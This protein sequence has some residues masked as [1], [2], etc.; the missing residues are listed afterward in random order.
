MAS[1]VAN[2]SAA[3]QLNDQWAIDILSKH[4]CI[5]RVPRKLRQT[6][7]A[8]YTPEVVPIGPFYSLR[9]GYKKMEKQKQKYLDQ[10]FC[11][12]TGKK[13]ED[14]TSSR[15]C[16]YPRE[17]RVC[18]YMLV[19][20]NLVVTAKDVDLLVDREVFANVLG[21]SDAA[22]EL[23]NKLCNEIVADDESDIDSKHNLCKKLN[24]YYENPWN[25]AMATLASTYFTDIWRGSET[26]AGLL[27]LAFTFW[28]F[29]RPS[30]M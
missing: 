19:L 3:I 25:R 7:E 5:Y 24:D 29:F 14:L 2:D 18:M 28:S 17:T 6:N 9:G 20:D 16:H 1:P 30:T 22:S 21:G 27:V 8:A 12:N 26:I 13:D 11:Q 15:K 23:I 10:F 4:C